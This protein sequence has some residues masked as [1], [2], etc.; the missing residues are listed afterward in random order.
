MY[1]L[2]FLDGDV[3]ANRKLTGLAQDLELKGTQLNTCVFILFVGY[4]CGQVPSN[5]IFDMVHST[6]EDCW[7]FWSPRNKTV[8]QQKQNIKLTLTTSHSLEPSACR[9]SSSR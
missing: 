6:F 4:L 7:S 5:M 1:V 2:N 9:F 8:C 3:I